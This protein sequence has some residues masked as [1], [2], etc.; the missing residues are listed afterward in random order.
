[1][2]KMTAREKHI[3]EMDTMVAICKRAQALGVAHGTMMTQMMDIQHA[4]E[5]FDLRLDDLLSAQDFDF[6]HDFIG[7]QNNID[8]T[9]GGKIER[10]VPRYA[11]N[12]V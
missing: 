5:Q 2:A 4:H 3:H 6:C 8:R 10:F 12:E 11:G 1:M 7:I 9:N